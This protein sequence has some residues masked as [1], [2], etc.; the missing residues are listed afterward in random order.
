[1]L[2]PAS[3]DAENMAFALAAAR[4]LLGDV[5][6]VAEKDH[7]IPLPVF[8][9]LRHYADNVDHRSARREPADYDDPVAYDTMF[10]D[11]CDMVQCATFLHTHG[12]NYDFAER[13]DELNF[14]IGMLEPVTQEA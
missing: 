14:Y 6:T 11:L 13:I 2:D 12:R 3:T 10:R 1:M 4:A 8:V 5:L 7:A 9:A